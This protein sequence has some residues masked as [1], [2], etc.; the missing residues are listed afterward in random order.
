GVVCQTDERPTTLTPP[1]AEIASTAASSMA[2][3]S[4]RFDPSP[5][6]VVGASTVR[7]APAWGA[8]VVEPFDMFALSSSELGMVIFILLL[9]VA[10]GKLAG[11]AEALGSW[12]YRRKVAR[13]SGGAPPER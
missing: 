2:R 12:L 9:V 11:L 3:R 4:P 1:I 5:M 13:E 10:S 7:R 8:D 6:I